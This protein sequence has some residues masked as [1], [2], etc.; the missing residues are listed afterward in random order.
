MALL[1]VKNDKVV[2]FADILLDCF[3]HV[4]LRPE[5]VE[6]GCLKMD[7]VANRPVMRRNF[8]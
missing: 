7:A 4:Q 1:A 2:P 6:I 5:L 8:F 3:V